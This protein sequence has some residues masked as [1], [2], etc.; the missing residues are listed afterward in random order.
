MDVHSSSVPGF[1]EIFAAEE[2]VK[3]ALAPTVDDVRTAVSSAVHQILHGERRLSVGQRY[4]L[5]NLVRPSSDLPESRSVPETELPQFYEELRTTLSAIV[6]EDPKVLLSSIMRCR[7]AVFVEEQDEQRR[8]DADRYVRSVQRVMVDRKQAIMK[9]IE[10][11]DLRHGIGT[12][13]SRGEAGQLV[14][15]EQRLM[16]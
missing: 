4:A 16:P 12:L 2:R 7:D 8:N 1:P 6:N 14:Y 11:I 5:R 10:L 3:E 15:P 9:V 13:R